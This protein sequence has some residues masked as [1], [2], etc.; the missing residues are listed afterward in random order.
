MNWFQW[1]LW[2]IQAIPAIWK[3][4][5][6]IE[7]QFPLPGSQKIAVLTDSIGVLASSDVG[8]SEKDQKKAV[9]IVEKVS[10]I[11]VKAFNLSGQFSTSKPGPVA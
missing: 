7:Q 8:M 2:L 6:E 10:A 5:R 3:A 1:A 4:V 11:A 9:G